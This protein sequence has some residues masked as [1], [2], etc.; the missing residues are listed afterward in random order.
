MLDSQSL[1]NS[2]VETSIFLDVL[3]FLPQLS[4]TVALTFPFNSE[5]LSIQNKVVKYFSTHPVQSYFMFGGV[6]L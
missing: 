5:G 2:A 1:L 6:H 4:N 3:V